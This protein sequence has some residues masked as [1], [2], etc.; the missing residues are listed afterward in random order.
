MLS[1]TLGAVLGALVVVVSVVVIRRPLAMVPENTMKYA[2][3]LLLSS[4]GLFWVVEGLGFFGA[5][6]ESLA[7]PGGTWA[8]PAILLAWLVVTRATVA[9][10][11]RLAPS[12]AASP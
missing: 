6:G 1:A 2:V 9:I 10:L 12:L 5:G 4:F 8:L 3:G 7:W 11:K